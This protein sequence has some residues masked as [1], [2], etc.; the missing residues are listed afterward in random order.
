MASRG[1]V[2]DDLARGQHATG[3]PACLA[4]VDD[5]AS[6]PLALGADHVHDAKAQKAR[7]VNG[8]V[9]RAPAR[10]ARACVV[11]MDRTRTVTYVA[12]D[13]ALVRD[14]AAH[15]LLGLLVIDV[16]LVDDVP[17]GLG[18]VR[19]AATR[20]CLP[21]RAR[22][23][24]G[25]APK[26]AHPAEGVA[27]RLARRAV[28]GA[29]ERVAGLHGII[30]AALVGVGK[31]GVCLGD[32]LEFLLGAGLLVDVGVVLARQLLERLANCRVI[33][34]MLDAKDGVVVLV[35]HGCHARMGSRLESIG[36][37]WP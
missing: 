15:A 22:G 11:R 8:D 9:S 26:A 4:R 20:A 19:A 3:A 24:E 13:V 28:G 1:N 18:V 30:A 6:R 5:H 31:Y 7:Q 32:L 21:P 25:P 23:T 35:V 29:G 34:V 12:R 10:G 33:G 37:D 27:L 14:A 16:K 17:S 2:H 36:L